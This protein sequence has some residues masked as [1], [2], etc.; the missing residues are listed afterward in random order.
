MRGRGRPTR[1]RPQVIHWIL[2]AI[3][4]GTSL[5]AAASRAG[6][7]PTTAAR[8]VQRGERERARLNLVEEDWDMRLTEWLEQFPLGHEVDN[9]LWSA[10]P[11]AEVDAK[12][13]PFLVFLQLLTR[14]SAEFEI[15][16]VATIRSAAANGSWRAAAWLLERW[17][18][19]DWG[20]RVV[21]PPGPVTFRPRLRKS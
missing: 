8:W 16:A 15:V 9:P 1:C 3:E 12:E 21:H 7:D 2:E 19:E 10:C 17:N 5:G 20:R 14:F 13:W 18:P 11:P 4:V 6:L